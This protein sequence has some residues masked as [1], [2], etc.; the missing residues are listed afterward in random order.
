MQGRNVWPHFCRFTLVGLLGAGVQLSCIYLLTKCLI[1]R[2]VCAAPLAV[3]IALLHNFIWH[4]RFTWRDRN[5]G[6]FAQR[7]IRLWRFH[8]GNGFISLFGNTVVIYFL[9][10][11]LKA[12]VLPSTI[13]AIAL[14]AL[15]NFLIA[16]RWVYC[17]RA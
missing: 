8:A 13:A 11:R 16:D 10:D 5:I 7:N 15:L 14:C 4:E 9:V 17:S 6:G 1:A 3:E 12:P 2:A